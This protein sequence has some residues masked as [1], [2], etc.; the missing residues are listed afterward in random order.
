MTVYLIDKKT[1]ELK[2]TFNNVIKWAVNFVEYNNVGRAKVYCNTDVE[3]F[4][5]ENPETVEVVDEETENTESD[6]Q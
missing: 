2:R 3:Y 1:N 4:S 6:N 5:D